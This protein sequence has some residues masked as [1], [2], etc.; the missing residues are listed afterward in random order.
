MV[1][2][3][4]MRAGEWD[5]TE[6][7]KVTVDSTVLNE[8]VKNFKA[9]VRGVDLAV[10]ENHEPDHKALGRVR[11]VYKKGK[12]QLYATIELTRQ[13]AEILT[14]GLYKYFSPE[15]YFT[16]IDEETGKIVKNLLVGGAFTN[17]PF[18]KNMEPMMAS[19]SVV[20]NHPQNKDNETPSKYLFIF[21][22]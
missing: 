6:Y 20:S 13:G 9:N 8:V 14:Q 17:R 4:I 18:F 2:I 12:D 19:E 1:D 15:I 5:H 21:K 11:D 10:D 7:G 22:D 16:K 3:Q